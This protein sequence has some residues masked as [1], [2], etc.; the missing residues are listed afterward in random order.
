MFYYIHE[1]YENSIT[2]NLSRFKRFLYKIESIKNFPSD[3]LNLTWE[4]LVLDNKRDTNFFM[5]RNE[6]VHQM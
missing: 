5:L 2:M 1:K 6:I 4:F 3:F